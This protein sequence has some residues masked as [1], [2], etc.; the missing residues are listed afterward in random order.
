MKNYSGHDKQNTL[1]NALALASF[2]GA[3]AAAISAVGTTTFDGRLLLAIILIGVA[4]LLHNHVR[5]RNLDEEARQGLAEVIQLPVNYQ[6]NN[7]DVEAT[8]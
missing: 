4:G 7:T 5:V 3:I 1:Y 8:N 6:A 2:L